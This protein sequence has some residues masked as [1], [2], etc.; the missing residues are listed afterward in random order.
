MKDFCRRLIYLISLFLTFIPMLSEGKMS[1]QVYN[2]EA[3]TSEARMHEDASHKISIEGYFSYAVPGYPDLPSKLYWI[4][5]PPDVDEQTKEVE[6]IVKR[7]T[8]LGQYNINKMPPLLPRMDNKISHGEAAEVFEQD[9]FFPEN[10]VE[11][12][13]FSRMRKWRLVRIR[14]TPFQYNPV[15]R[16][17]NAIPEVGVTVKYLRKGMETVSQAE[18]TD[19]VMDSRA[20][21][22]IMNFSESLDWY[23]AAEETATASSIYNYIIITTSTIKYTYSWYL[24]GDLVGHLK[25][26]GYKPLVVTEF[27]FGGLVGQYPNGTAEKIRKWLQDHYLS[28]GIE[29]V[30]LIGNP[31][32]DDPEI[33]DDT[34]GN[35]PMKTCLGRGSDY[36]YADLTGNWDL[37]GDGVFAEYEDDSGPGGVDFVNEVYVGRIPFYSS[38]DD[39]VSVLT[40]IVNYGNETNIFWRRNALLPMPF[41]DPTTDKAYFGEAMVSGYLAGA[42]FLHWKMYQQGTAYAEANSIFASDEELRGGKTKDRWS[43]NKYGAVWWAGHGNPTETWIGWGD[44]WDGTVMT[45]S[46]VASLNDSYP[47]FV[48][49]SSCRN[50]EP[51]ISN[52][53]GKSLL[54]HGAI[55][56][57]STN[58]TSWYAGGNWGTWL[59]YYCDDSSIGYYYGEELIKSNKTAGKALFDVKSDMGVNQNGDWKW[60]SWKNLFGY[61]LYG[62]PSVSILENGIGPAVD[63]NFLQ[64]FTIGDVTAVWFIQ[65]AT[66]YYDGDAAQSGDITHGESVS[67]FSKVTGPATLT[68]YWKVSSEENYDFLEFKIDGFTRDKISGETGWE[69]ETYTIP[70]GLHGISWTY[71]KDWSVSSGSDCGWLDKV[72]VQES[73]VN[74]G[75]FLLLLG[76]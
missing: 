40:K 44:H 70:A 3:P 36:F 7:K 31:D 2:F 62:D 15:T 68:F 9:K 67:I 1:F 59:K 69:K 24:S 11:N 33:A 54:Y 65:F 52:N 42:G 28:Y 58:R 66:Y 18:L 10:P 60:D 38:S 16:H 56:T 27:E 47:S 57:L 45:S 22:M 21:E 74:P 26:K 39:L 55:A 48:F 23:K 50:G 6:Y 32:P 30:L 17:V 37:D 12:L 19:N 8:P 14:Y 29:Y 53:L 51:E 43:A 63:N 73:S 72:V 4:A 71:E 64:W 35:I 76:D 61:N 49:Q 5:V 75:V 25:N 13:G 46:D 34:V 20:K 41:Q